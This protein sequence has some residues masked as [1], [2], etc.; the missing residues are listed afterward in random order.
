MASLDV[1]PA[2]FCLFNILLR[3]PAGWPPGR[4]LGTLESDLDRQM[5]TQK[6]N[7]CRPQIKWQHF[8]A[9]VRLYLELVWTRKDR[10]V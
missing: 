4:P 6:V 3:V 5:W 10:R 2:P 1:W 9:N 8:C 7:N